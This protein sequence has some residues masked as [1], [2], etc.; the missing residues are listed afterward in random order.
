MKHET[1][2]R[3][4]QRRAWDKENM[5][6]ISCRVS[7]EVGQRFI[8]LASVFRTTRNGL[9]AEFVRDICEA[10][11]EP[12]DSDLDR[13]VRGE[14]GRR[15]VIAVVEPELLDAFERELNRRQ[16]RKNEVLNQLIRDY[17]SRG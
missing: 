1:E 13:R 8:D 9:I 4:E 12:T 7:K 16:D 15:I 3:V 17:V 10:C 5:A 6:T 2:K 14:E 11:P